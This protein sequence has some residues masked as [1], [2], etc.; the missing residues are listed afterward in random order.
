MLLRLSYLALTSVF[1]FIRLLP[2]S[3]TDKDIEILTLRHQL[4]VL[5]RQIDKPRLTPPDQAPTPMATR[6]CSPSDG[7][8]GSA[9]GRSRAATAVGRH[10][11]QRLVADGET[12]LDVPAK[13]SARARVFAT[14]QGR[15]TD[16]VD[17]HS[18]AVAA[19]RPIG[20]RQVVVDDATVALRLLAD[21]RDELGR[22]RTDVVN[23]LHVLLLDL[24]AGGAKRR[25]PRR[26]PAPCWPRSARVTSSAVPA[27]SWPASWSPSSP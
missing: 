10:I 9:C 25:C 20:L 17:A 12:V 6:R 16:P 26:R 27:G 8:I 14:G 18:V 5:Q 24:V 13:L 4:A 19:L 21:R 22:A 15:K 1:A 11:A 3:D 7:V 23:R 2:M